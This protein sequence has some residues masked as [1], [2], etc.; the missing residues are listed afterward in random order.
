ME[1]SKG[2]GR[3][4]GSFSDQ[5]VTANAYRAE[6]MGLLAIHKIFK[7]AKEIWPN[8][9]GRVRIYS[10]CLGALG[11]VADLPPHKIPSKSAIQTY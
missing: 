6:L 5:L 11:R 8:L 1:C 4:I 3:I 2:S 10:D 7:A 9:N